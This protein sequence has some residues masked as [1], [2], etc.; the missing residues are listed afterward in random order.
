MNSSKT[1]WRIL[2]AVAEEVVGSPIIIL[3]KRKGK[4]LFYP[5]LKY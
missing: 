1:R 2:E 4:D 5:V 3:K